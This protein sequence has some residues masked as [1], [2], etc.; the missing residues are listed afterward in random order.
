[1]EQSCEKKL[2]QAAQFLR[3]LG[4]PM[5]LA[6]VQ[7]LKDRQWCVCELASYLKLNKSVA[8]KHLATLKNVGVIKMTKEGTQVICSLIMPCIFDMLL[9]ANFFEEPMNTLSKSQKNCKTDSCI[10]RN[11]Q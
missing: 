7:A 1:M 11:E 9:C 4:H 2:T 3:A 8:S 6:M 5:R 10:I